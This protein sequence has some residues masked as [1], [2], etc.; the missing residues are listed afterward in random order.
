M[1]R[2]IDVR[3]SMSQPHL[4]STTRRASDA[5]LLARI[6]LGDAQAFDR[7]GRAMIPGLCTFAERYVRSRE[8]AEELVQDVLFHV[9]M[10]RAELVVQDT[11]T[12]YLYRAVRNRALNWAR[13]RATQRGLLGRL[14]LRTPAPDRGGVLAGP[15]ARL[16]SA[17]VATA[18]RRAVEKLPDRWRLAF[19]LVR[20]HQLTRA[21]AAAVLGVTVR[22]IDMALGRAVKALRESLRGVW[23]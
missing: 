12:T 6:R 7:L 16:Q 4:D 11:V 23:P 13:D 15:E 14:A 17:Q 18:L 20:E 2:R 19:E 22:S 3:R 10:H 5:E 1:P 9:W 8:V 21:E